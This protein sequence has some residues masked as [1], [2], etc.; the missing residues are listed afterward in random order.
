MTQIEKQVQA[1]R[2]RLWLNDWLRL[3]CLTTIFAAAAFAI[4]TAIV[5]LSSA[6]L[7]L[8][9]TALGLEVF[10]LVVALIWSAARRADAASAAVALDEAA[11]LRERISSGLYC[12]ASDDPFARAVQQDAERISA[13]VT[14]RKHI[15]LRTPRAAAY[16][17]VAW[18]LAAGLLL[19]PEGMLDQSQAKQDVD[20]RQGVE[21]TKVA[22]RK[23]FDTLKKL[24]GDSSALEDLQKDLNALENPLPGKLE[25]PID[26]RH[27]AIKKIEKMSDSLREKR[28]TEY[29][30]RMAEMRKM[31]RGLKTSKE[32]RSDVAKLRKAL[33]DNDFKAAQQSLRNLQ[34]QLRKLQQD[35]A[36]PERTRE[37]QK[38][39]EELAQKL[40][41]L[42]QNKQLVQK[43]E[44]AG[45][46]KEAIEKALKNL[47]KEDIERMRKALEKQGL[48]QKQIDDLMKQ[49]QKRKASSEWARKMADSLKKC[50]G[51]C[52]SGNMGEAAGDLEG[53]GQMLSEAEMLEQQLAEMDSMLAELDQMQNDLDSSCSNCNGMGCS[54]CQGTGMRR[55]GQGKL[56]R[57]QGGLAREQKTA[58]R[59]KIERTKVKTTQGRIIG[60]FLVDGEQVKGAATA[61]VREALAAAER[62]ATEAINRDR[63][64][65]HY[66]DAVKL[67]FS[68]LRLDLGADDTTEP[69]ADPSPTDEE[70]E[71]QGGDKSS[72]D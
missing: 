65:R 32:P 52:A 14:A 44:Q 27:A 71:G 36:N 18:L 3:A 22:V 38:Q 55:G 57:G 45:L 33:A 39:L 12:A 35:G 40:E 67:Y 60:Q 70:H 61:Q 10:A 66:Q 20:E 62:E 31:L 6:D 69:E 11:G 48:S 54:Q 49:L 28:E 23:R 1:T 53:A 25:R 8:A 59:S 42:A 4:V 34:Q 5:R 7:P 64:P 63:V 37:M 9:W 26:I 29:S 17:A 51:S 16:T 56:G 43:L 47:T 30:Q 19:L 58:T 15:R 24:A 21:R 41:E 72:S 13:T 68:K 2:N 46:D 50:A